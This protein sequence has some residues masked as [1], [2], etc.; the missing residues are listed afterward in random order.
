MMNMDMMDMNIENGNDVMIH[1]P[2]RSS[3]DQKGKQK[4][5]KNHKRDLFCSADDKSMEYFFHHSC[6]LVYRTF[7]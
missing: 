7:V 4:P 3:R 6:L 1:E 5:R 2:R